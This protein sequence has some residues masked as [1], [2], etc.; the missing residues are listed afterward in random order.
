MCKVGTG[1]GRPD[2]IRAGL[3]SGRVSVPFQ[4]N[5]VGLRVF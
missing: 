5:R 1:L 2:G 4:I 3:K